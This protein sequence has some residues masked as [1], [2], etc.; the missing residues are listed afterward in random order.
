MGYCSDRPAEPAVN[1]LPM[2]P[3]HLL[4]LRPVRTAR[5]GVGLLA[6]STN[7]SPIRTD[8]DTLPAYPSVAL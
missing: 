7:C 4:R 3:V 1:L 6:E 2:S 8:W 5:Q